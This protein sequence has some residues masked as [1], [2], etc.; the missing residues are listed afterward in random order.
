MTGEVKEH[1]WIHRVTRQ[2]IRA[3]QSPGPDYDK[4]PEP[5]ENAESN[6]MAARVLT[7]EEKRKAEEPYDPL[8]YGLKGKGR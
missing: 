7:A 1:H 6:R 4:V 5:W 8:R 2:V 3:E